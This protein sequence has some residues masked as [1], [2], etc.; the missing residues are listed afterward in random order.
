MVTITQLFSRTLILAMS[1]VLHYP[2]VYKIMLFFFFLHLQPNA[3]K[4]YGM[5][6][7]GELKFIKFKFIYPINILRTMQYT[8]KYDVLCFMKHNVNNAPFRNDQIIK[9]TKNE[10]IVPLCLVSNVV[11]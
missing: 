11:N 10:R 7:N 9:D 3:N 5:I 2:F 1:E 6:K 8:S 4:C